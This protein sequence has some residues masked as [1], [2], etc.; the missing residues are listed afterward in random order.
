MYHRLYYHVPS[1]LYK[2]PTPHQEESGGKQELP[3]FVSTIP[4]NQ[5]EQAS[6]SLIEQSTS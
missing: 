5:N 3:L 4:V 2:R 6:K 1:L